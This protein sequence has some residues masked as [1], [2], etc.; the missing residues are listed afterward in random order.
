MGPDAQQ[1]EHGVI[2]DRVDV[3][4]HCLISPE[5]QQRSPVNIRISHQ[6]LIYKEALVSVAAPYPFV[7]LDTIYK[8]HAAAKSECMRRHIPDPVQKFIA[9]VKFCAHRDINKLMHR[10][11]FQLIP[12]AIRYICKPNRASRA[13]SG[14]LIRRAAVIAV[15]RIQCLFPGLSAVN[16]KGTETFSAS[17]LQSSGQFRLKFI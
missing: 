4:R 2:H 12:A 17:D 7:P 8:K 15:N 9:A 16:R 11:H 14:V 5:R 1:P 3:S 13:S 6:I 10:S